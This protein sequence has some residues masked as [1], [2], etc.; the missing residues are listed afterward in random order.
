MSPAQGPVR[1]LRARVPVG[2]VPSLHRLRSWRCLAALCLRPTLGCLR[3][4]HLRARVGFAIAPLAP[5]LVLVRRLRRYYGPVRLPVLV[6][7]GLTPFGFPSRPAAPSA[8]G[9]HGTSRFPREVL[10]SM[11]GV[12]DRAGTCLVSP[13][14]RADVAFRFHPQRRLP[15]GVISRLNTQP[16]LSP[17]NASPRPLRCRGA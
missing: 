8:A 10:P 13:W 17:V 2:R 14:R 4:F 16:A 12:S 3:C 15:E 5:Q 9:E 7:L 1:V 6:H 11:P